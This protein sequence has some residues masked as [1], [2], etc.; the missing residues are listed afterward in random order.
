MFGGGWV[1]LS[2]AKVR[3]LVFEKKKMF[4][5]RIQIT[6]IISFRPLG[7]PQQHDVKYSCSD[8]LQSI[9]FIWKACAQMTSF[10][11]AKN[12]YARDS[13]RHIFPPL[14]LML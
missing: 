7:G 11:S 12:T 1:W 4:I 10:R 6:Q 2:F 8:N 3:W 13:F 9:A 14:Y 5:L